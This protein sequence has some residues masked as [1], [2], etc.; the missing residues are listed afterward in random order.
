MVKLTGTIMKTIFELKMKEAMT[1]IMVIAMRAMKMIIATVL[2][3]KLN[4]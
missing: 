3:I 1:M 2:I 4:I